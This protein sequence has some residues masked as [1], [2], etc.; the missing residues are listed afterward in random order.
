MITQKTYHLWKSIL[1]V[2]G[3][4]SIQFIFLQSLDA[5]TYHV[6]QDGSDRNTGTINSPLGSLETALKRMQAGDTCLVRGGRYLLEENISRISGEKEQPIVVQAYP[7]ERV[8]FDGTVNVKGRWRK[9]KGNIYKLKVKQDI[10][11]LFA[12][13]E[14]V[15]PA[16]WPNAQYS[17]N[18]V[19][20][21]KNTWAQG[22]ETLDNRTVLHNDVKAG[23]SLADLGFSVE[24]AMAILNIGSF[25]THS[26]IVTSHKKGEES[27]TFNRVK[28]YRPKHHDYYLE[29]KLEL[30][31]SENEWYFD[32]R[33]KT[34]YLW[35][36]GGGKPKVKI[37]GKIQ[38]YAIEFKDSHFIT[39]QGIEF[40]GTTLKF[41]NCTNIQVE[42]CDFI[43]PSYTRRMLGDET[44]DES[45]V[46]LQKNKK[47]PS[48]C[49][50][51][52]CE[53]AY[54]DGHAL[55]MM[56]THNRVE[57]SSFHHIDY[58]ASSI[59]GLMVSILLEGQ[60]NVFRRNTIH[61]CAASS[62][63]SAG[64]F[65]LVELN[66]VWNTGFLQN[67]GSITQVTIPGQPGSIIRN[68]WFRN[69]IKSGAR[70]DAP[71][72][73]VRWGNGGQMNHNVMWGSNQGI[74]IKGERHF[75]FNNTTLNT[76]L[77]GIIILDDADV[78]GGAN[79]GTVTRNN[80]SDKLSGH[81]RKYTPVPGIVDH[82]WNAYE[83]KGDYRTLLR[84]P[85]NWDFRPKTGAEIIDAGRV[86]KGRSENFIGKAPDIG[87]YEHGAKDYWIPGR[88]ESVSS[89]PIPRDKNAT[90]KRD[91]DL[92]WLPAYKSQMNL[93]YFGESEAGVSKA[94]KESDEYRGSQSNNIFSPGPLKP[95]KTYFWRI[96]SVV[97]K[98]IVSGPVWSFTV[99]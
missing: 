61:S 72:P 19:W 91:A 38:S 89:I 1:M 46:F 70:F 35:Q 29:G 30:L 60:N 74:M 21:K 79:K 6:S 28:G 4:M 90:A 12:D 3:M 85:D 51:L 87:A 75:C 9:Y 97:G 20:D 66:H 96:D 71:I 5:A 57:N 15:V 86:V 34:L 40:F 84:D 93:V 64:D 7:G 44:H 98:E 63:I 69:T 31:D 92:M 81:R 42:D 45:T 43:Y 48:Y 50:I 18:S 22:I 39:I 16:R 24:G 8:V 95:G 83:N 25:T 68:N 73:P 32:K 23:F 49:T 88:K 76:R 65:P 80:F 41:S 59:P 14:M 26:R 17:D 36:T 10:W 52:N 55:Y 27:F 62:T 77:N 47:S 37:Q 56:G 94:G 33:S 78:K 11:Q 53:F 99:E 58:S 67:D 13:G 54:T 2:G 82:N